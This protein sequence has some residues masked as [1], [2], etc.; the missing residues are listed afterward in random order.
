MASSGNM[1]VASRRIWSWPRRGLGHW[2][3]KPSVRVMAVGSVVA[4]RRATP[5][6][7]DDLWCSCRNDGLDCCRL[8]SCCDM[9]AGRVGGRGGLPCSPCDADATDVSLFGN[10]RASC[11]PRTPYDAHAGSFPSPCE[12]LSAY[13][14]RAASA[15]PSLT[16]TASLR[17][18]T[19][20]WQ[21]EQA[22]AACAGSAESRLLRLAPALPRASQ[23]ACDCGVSDSKESSLSHGT[24]DACLSLETAIGVQG[25]A[26]SGSWPQ[27]L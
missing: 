15:L 21:S 16:V 19:R 18:A 12:S 9:V 17:G 14:C 23:A 11:L 8:D 6:A 22:F 5:R 25:L 4:V 2:L 7:D 26:T 1:A 20:G 24:G 10:R 3:D 27:S 13:A